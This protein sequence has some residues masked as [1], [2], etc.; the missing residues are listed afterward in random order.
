M[1]EGRRARRVAELLRMHVT[2][3]IA[4]ELGDPSLDALVIT[5]VDVPDDLS[6]ARIGVRLMV[7]DDDD[8]ARKRSLRSLHRASGRLRRMLAPRLELR[9]VPELSFSY[10]TGHDAERRVE[11]LLEEIHA[12]SPED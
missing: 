6:V 12:E 7:G 9:R 5:T 8:K 4:R 1:S 11:E 2:Q 10:D 3:L